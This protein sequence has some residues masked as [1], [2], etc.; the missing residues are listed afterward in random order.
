MTRAT[1]DGGRPMLSVLHV[2]GGGCGGCALEVS[3]LRWAGQA[4]PEAGFVMVETPRHADVLLVSG[5]PTRNLVQAI[6]AAWA[7]MPG[8][9]R[10]VA[11]GACAIDGGP[12]RD[13]YAV[14]GGLEGRFPVTVAVP[15]CPP[16]PDAILDGLCQL[17]RGAPGGTAL[18]VSEPS[19]EGQVAP[20][21]RPDQPV[22]VPD[23][24]AP[25][26]AGLRAPAAA[27]P[28]PAPPRALLPAAPRHPLAGG[29]SSAG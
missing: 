6:D 24:P 11:V 23:N 4:L 20:S 26:I 19:A 13:S 12:F 2:D 17:H 25:V 1:G 28:A 29:D 8:P 16:T 10:L 14:S 3:A 18:A 27:S 15:G 21:R 22:A 7:A 9:K 5:C